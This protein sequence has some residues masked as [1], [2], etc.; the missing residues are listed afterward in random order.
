M[1]KQ[2]LEIKRQE[3]RGRHINFAITPNECIFFFFDPKGE[4]RYLPRPGSK[5]LTIRRSW[6]VRNCPIS[7]KDSKVLVVT[8]GG[9]AASGISSEFY[10]QYGDEIHSKLTIPTVE[11]YLE[12]INNPG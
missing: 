9:K 6:T 5:P 10:K 8:T 11:S 7:E 3:K 1:Q 2:R 4:R 12:K